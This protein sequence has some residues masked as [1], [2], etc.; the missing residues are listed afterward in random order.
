VRHKLASRF[1]STED[2][3]FCTRTGRALGQRN[4]LCA[5][6]SAMRSIR[7]VIR[8]S[9]SLHV[10]DEHSRPVP[11]GPGELSSMHSF[12]HTVASRRFASKIGFSVRSDGHHRGGGAGPRRTMIFGL[13][14]GP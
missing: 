7:T 10:T 9:P 8:P 11:A 12:R 4:V 13:R 3:V 2:F 6:R 5:L 14:S 1:V